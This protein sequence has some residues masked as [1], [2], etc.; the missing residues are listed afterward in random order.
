MAVMVLFTCAFVLALV[1]VTAA[2]ERENLKVIDRNLE[3]LWH[4]QNFAVVDEIVAENYVRHLP[5]GQEVR[6]REGYIEQH[7]KPNMAWKWRFNK[8]LVIPK[9]DYVIVRYSNRGTDPATGKPVKGSSI[10]IHSLKN[11][12]LVED[13]AEWDVLN[14]M[15]QVGYKLVPPSEK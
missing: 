15:E 4:K 7:I 6:G 1:G 9:G 3:E 13:W 12:K 5:G 2:G 10:V 8:D 11:G 14:L